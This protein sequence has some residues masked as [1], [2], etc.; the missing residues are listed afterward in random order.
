[1]ER[2]DWVRL[3]TNWVREGGLVEFRASRGHLA[4]ETAALMNLVAIAHLADGQT[5][6]ARATY[7][8][9]VSITGC[10]RE[11]VARARQILGERKL[12]DFGLGGSWCRLE[13]YQPDAGGWAKLPCKKLYLESRI[14][15]FSEFF[16]RKRIELD[17][18]KL[19]FLFLTF[20]DN[21][22]NLAVIGY[23]KIE[24]YTG[25]SRKYIRSGVSF[26][27]NLGLIHVEKVDNDLL[28]GNSKNHYRI[29]GI[30]SYNHRGTGG[31][32]GDFLGFDDDKSF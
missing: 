30:D 27:V 18:L 12:I 28:M 7:D 2:R 13:D 9:L 4:N 5:G 29:I 19:Y 24:E 25:I 17:A 15:V 21:Y 11:K 6:V 16:L 3:P 10:S 20:R 1:M 31:R 32:S 14:E 23:D 26:L 22:E 8:D